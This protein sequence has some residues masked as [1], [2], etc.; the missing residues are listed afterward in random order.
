MSS[1]TKINNRKKDILIL[2]KGLMQGLEHGLSAKKFYS[3]NFT[4]KKNNFFCLSL[5][6]N[7]KKSYLFVYGTKII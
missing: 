3:I 4:E 6:Y 7:K 1:S 2:G 5:H